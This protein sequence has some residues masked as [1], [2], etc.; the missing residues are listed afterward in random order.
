MRLGIDPTIDCAFK[1]MFG[2]EAAKPLLLDLLRAVLGDWMGIPILELRL[3]NPFNDKETP[4]DKLSI[5]DIKAEDQ[6]GRVYNVEM[7]R[8]VLAV[9][10]HRALYYW[11]RDHGQA[12]Q[13]GEGYETLR[14]S[15]GVHILGRPLF[16][17]VPDY[18]L[19]FSLRCDQHH[20][21]RLTSSLTIHTIE[22]SKFAKGAEELEE[23]LEKW[24][25]FLRHA[26]D[27]EPEALPE[28]LQTPVME[29]AVEVLRAMMR[30]SLERELYEAQLKARRDHDAFILEAETRVQKSFEKGIEK[31][32]A[33]G[34]RNTLETILDLKFGEAG[35]KLME[36]IRAI[37]NLAKLQELRQALKAARTL[38]EFRARLG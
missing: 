20:E 16:P 9:Y 15:A 37:E 21:L 10:A 29:Q 2:S 38:D 34:E 27:L 33:Q 30:N 25:Y 1:K 32:L 36:P 7:Q 24:C 5:L 17:Q 31:G 35:L 14:A 13:E 11:S 19:S 18:H 8:E 28:P 3:L 12:L 4:S 6:V 22:L 26:E 23:P